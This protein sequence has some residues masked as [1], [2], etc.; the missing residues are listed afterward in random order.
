MK[1]GFQVVTIALPIWRSCVLSRL[2]Y[3]YFKAFSTVF[4]SYQ[5]DGRVTMTGSFTVRKISSSSGV[6][7]V[8]VVVVVLLFY[9]HG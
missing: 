6:R 4:Q 5:D 3:A 7:F 9:V 1:E 2:T 8:V